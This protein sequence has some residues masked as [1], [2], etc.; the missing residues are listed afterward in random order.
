[1]PQFLT[2]ASMLECSMGAAPVPFVADDLPGAPKETGLTCATIIQFVPMKNIMTFG[3]C[4]SML[5]PAVASATAAA[6]GVLTPM[7]CVP[8]TTTPWAPP[9]AAAKHFGIP[10]ATAS[11][12]CACAFGG[13]IKVSQQIPEAGKTL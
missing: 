2:T 6:Q 10:L 4:K 8:A 9:S 13:L 5:N 12:V 1:M 11:S 3:M 7:P